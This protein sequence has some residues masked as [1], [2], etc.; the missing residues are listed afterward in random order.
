MSPTASSDRAAALFSK[1]L[2]TRT[3][4]SGAGSAFTPRN[5]RRGKAAEAG[6]ASTAAAA[7][8][9][10]ERRTK[11]EPAKTAGTLAS[12]RQFMARSSKVL[13]ASA[14][15]H[16]AREVSIERAAC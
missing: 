7:G 15:G 9:N 14:G 4:L 6:V 2:P 5:G 3:W 13:S 8:V 10:T 1:I 16:Y 11:K 12:P